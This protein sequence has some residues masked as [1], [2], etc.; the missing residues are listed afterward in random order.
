MSKELLKVKIKN[1]TFYISSKTEKENW[2]RNEFKN[3]QNKQETL[4]RWHRELSIKGNIVYLDMKE[5]KYAGNVLSLILNN[6]DDNESYSLEIPIM[7]TGGSVRTTNQYFNSVAGTFKNLKKGDFVKMFVNNK[8]EDKNG[9]LYRNI[10]VLDEDDNLIKSDFSYM[11]APKWSVT[12]TK[13][14]FGKEVKKYDATET[15]KFYINKF[16]ESLSSFNG[17]S[18]PTEQPSKTTEQPTQPKGITPSE[19]FA[20][21]EEDEDNG[22]PF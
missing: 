16:Q 20:T 14:E 18:Q 17:D 2:T 8:K 3:P 19:A 11:D 22:L 7:D 12:V 1:G 10:V 21:V 13:D 5:D 6:K 15:N 4:I 9:R